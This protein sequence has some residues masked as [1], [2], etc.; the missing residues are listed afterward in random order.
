MIKDINH[1]KM[2]R[3][4]EVLNNR[5]VGLCGTRAHIDGE[6]M[7]Q[8][9][10]LI[11]R[12]RREWRLRGVD[13]PEL[14]CVPLTEVNALELVLASSTP[15]QLRAHVQAWQTKY[16]KLTAECISAGVALAFPKYSVQPH[17]PLSN[18]SYVRMA[19]VTDAPPAAN[20][21]IPA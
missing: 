20:E 8:V 7:V 12:H 6:L 5:I 9:N 10:D 21:G 11:K 2:R 4:E 18:K 13:V 15:M 1:E 3:A 14:V 17:K 19:T 16:P